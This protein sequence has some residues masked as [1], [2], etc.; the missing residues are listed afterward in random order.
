MEHKYN[1]RSRNDLVSITV[2]PSWSYGIISNYSKK[3]L[4]T[5]DTNILDKTYIFD[6]MKNQSLETIKN[7]LEK[8]IP[9]NKREQ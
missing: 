3:T 4:V 5:F 9:I 6:F 1:L 2:E 7:K 8:E